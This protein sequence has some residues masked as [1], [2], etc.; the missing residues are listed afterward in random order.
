MLFLG[1]L[2]KYLKILLGVNTL[3]YVVFFVLFWVDCYLYSVSDR[4]S[5]KR[6][7]LFS[8]FVREYVQTSVTI[9]LGILFLAA[10]LGINY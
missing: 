4:F 6:E 3:V 9:L 5:L 8:F 1:R 2:Q 10:A 7:P